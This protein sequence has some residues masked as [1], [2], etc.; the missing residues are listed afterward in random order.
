MPNPSIGSA[1]KTVSGDYT[2]V[3][4]FRAENNV[5]KAVYLVA[6]ALHAL[7]QCEDGSNP[8][9][10]KSCVSKNEVQPKLV[11]CGVLSQAQAFLFFVLDAKHISTLYVRYSFMVQL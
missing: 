3:T 8:T 9:T 7:M 1:L 4:I 5:Y 10:G 6:H 2:D 11:S